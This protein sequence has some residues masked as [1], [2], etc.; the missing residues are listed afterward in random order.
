VWGQPLSAVAQRAT[1]FACAAAMEAVPSLLD[2]VRYLSTEF[3]VQE[4]KT[5]AGAAGQPKA[6]VS[7]KFFLIFRSAAVTV[8]ASAAPALYR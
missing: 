6:A 8:E 3:P 1:T 2:Y 5:A 7:T 4:A